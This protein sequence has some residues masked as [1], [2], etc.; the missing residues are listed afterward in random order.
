MTR[1]LTYSQKVVLA[2][3]RHHPEYWARMERLE[4]KQIANIRKMRKR[5]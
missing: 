4:R 5:K 3:K 2:S 1:Q